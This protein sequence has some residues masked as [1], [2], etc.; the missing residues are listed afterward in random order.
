MNKI[1]LVTA[2][3]G[4]STHVVLGGSNC[5]DGGKKITLR[6]TTPSTLPAKIEWKN[7]LFP[8][9][10][11]CQASP[12][13]GTD[14][15][16]KWEYG[17]IPF[18][19]GNTGRSVIAQQLTWPGDG[20]FFG[21]KK[22]SIEYT[23]GT[24]T[25]KLSKDIKFLF[26]PTQVISS[27]PAWY[28]YWSGTDN[29]IPE[30]SNFSLDTLVGLAL[31]AGYMNGAW[32]L[33]ESK[34]V[35]GFKDFTD[36]FYFRYQAPKYYIAIEAYAGGGNLNHEKKIENIA[37]VIA[38]E[39]GHHEYN[40]TVRTTMIY[41]WWW[42]LTATERQNYLR[43]YKDGSSTSLKG[44]IKIR[45]DSTRKASETFALTKNASYGQYVDLSKDWSQGGEND[46]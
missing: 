4:M 38:H 9:N 7:S 32:G 17:D 12:S 46:D 27:T 29:A 31:R 19:N 44:A 6:V 45:I 23:G 36:E 20:S 18:P 42:A 33:C 5:A 30:L 37:E 16:L 2:L 1:L 24:G 28:K 21:E 15:K 14:S 10:Q 43:D 34:W 8:F 41:N 35:A 39:K 22:F 11:A 13:G 25:C 40:I 3:L 26:P